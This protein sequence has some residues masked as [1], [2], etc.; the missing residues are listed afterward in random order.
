VPSAGG[1][2]ARPR[3]AQAAAVAPRREETPAPAGAPAPRALARFEDIVALA[4]E[5]RDLMVKTALERDVR[6]VRVEDGR[7]DIA[8]EPGASKALANEL[9]RKL[10]LWTG[11]RWMVAISAEAGGP[12]LK[13]QADSRHEEVTRGIHAHPLVQAVM[14]RFPGAEITHVSPR[15]DTVAVP[16]Y[17]E[18]DAPA[19]DGEGP[20]SADETDDDEP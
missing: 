15:Q 6:P 7:L 20:W 8:L 1:A 11:R 13:Q 12:T 14:A 17:A 10:S 4:A 9:A 18:R 19:A 3:A 2:S 16:G 5:K